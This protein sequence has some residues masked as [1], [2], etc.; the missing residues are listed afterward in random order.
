MLAA[1][2]FVFLASFSI[3]Y[4]ENERS[5]V[6][7]M[8]LIAQSTRESLEK[9][10][11]DIEQSVEMA[12]NFATESLD[13]MVLVEDGIVGSGA[14]QGERTPQQ[15]EHLDSYLSDYS[16][17]VQSSFATIA[18]H[19]QGVI[20]YYYC[21]SPEVSTTEHGF[22]YSRA[23][24]TGFAERESLDAREL[25]P[26][27]TEHTVWY[28]LPIQRGRPSW[29]GPYTAH[30]LNEMWISSYVV[31]IYKSGT[32]IGVLGM[33]ISL[34]TFISQ[35]SSIRVYDTGFAYLLDEKGQVIYHPE[36][37][38]G[39]LL[40]LPVDQA[41]LQQESS[42]NTLIRYTRSGEERQ[43]SF[44]TLSNGMKLAVVAPTKEV[45]AS[46]LRLVKV[47]PPIA[48]AILVVFAAFILLS[49]RL[50][51]QPLKRLT[52]ASQRLATADYDVELNYAGRDEVGTL[53]SAFQRMRDQLQ[54]YIEDLNRQL[55]MDALTGLPNQRYFFDLAKDE[56]ARLQSEGKRPVVLYFNLRDMK[57]FNRQY[58]FD[59]GDKLICAV[60]TI[61]SKHFGTLRTSRFGQDHFAVVSH[62]EG[63]ESRLYAV[64]R[65][66]Q[67]INGGMTLPVSVGIY[68][69]SLGDVSVSVACDRAKY[70]CDSRK[71]VYVSGFRYFD[72]GML[73]QAELARYAMNHLDQALSEHWVQVY[74]QHIVDATSSMVCHEE[75][76][77]R[78]IDPVRGFMSPGDFI[79]AL[80]DSGLIYK[81]DL[82]V[83]DQVLI[84]IRAQEQAG[85]EVVPHS[86]N[87]SRSDFDSCDIVEE[88]VKRVDAAGVDRG[89]IAIEITESIIGSNFDFMKIQVARFQELGFPV[90]MDDFGSG[91]SSLDCLQSL[92]FD[93][94]KF[95]MS[96]L[97]KLDEGPNG[98]IILTDLV[99]MATELGVDTICEGV[100]SAEQARF[101]RDIG[102]KKLQGFYF[103]KPM[104][105]RG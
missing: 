87:L 4:S 90:W 45:N 8:A 43:M 102:C 79:P 21:I 46:S 71:G 2:V 42:G 38:S 99:G 89:L 94:I 26:N 67:D 95:D 11:E 7:K 101:L 44:T 23:G 36:L 54:D 17:R 98:K 65:D 50:I 33:D 24:K 69:Q 85:S 47:I 31:P 64:L 22:F 68:P 28:Y 14:A 72:E 29:V 73:R 48:A 80:E 63:L 60:A 1:I 62:E 86:I 9:Y 27:D 61:L 30:F 57:H 3:T 82:F 96:F 37:E 97:R 6:E 77:T 12:A 104:P 74:Y 70:A 34:D 20:T 66:C 10:T 15:T 92:E 41:I 55:H 32:F 39:T 56:I 5:S 103:S 100:E 76:L 81:L 83:L 18:S 19:T 40:E 78:W 49:M 13:G 75:A 52:A 59:E 105:W 58:G 88:I 53:T 35:V 51:T 16:K 84:K 25:D 91:Y 93:L